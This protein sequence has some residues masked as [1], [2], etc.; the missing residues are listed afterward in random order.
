M[1]NTDELISAARQATGLDDFGGDSFREGLSILVT[2]INADVDRPAEFVQRNAGMITKILIDRLMVVD[3]IAQRPEV[4]QQEVTRPVFILGLPRTGTTLLSNLLSVDPARRSA[5]K[6]ELEN[7]AP[8]PTTATL[9]TDP[10]ALA[11]IEEDRQ[12]LEAYPEAGKHNPWRPLYPHECVMI[13]QHEFNTLA[14]ESW[15]KLPNYRDF[16]FNSDWTKGY[17]YHKKFL[18]LHQIDAPGIWN[19]KMPSHALNVETLLKVYPDARL[20]WTHRDPYTAAGSL[21]SLISLGHGAYA[22][23]V[24]KEWIGQNYPWQSAQ[25]AERIMDARTRIGHDRIIDF[26]YADAVRDPMGEMRKLYAALGDEFTPETEAAMSAWLAE[27][28][29]GKFGRHEYKL[30]EYGVTKEAIAP[31]F[32]RYISEY[33]IE[34]EG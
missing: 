25:H 2:D 8:P 26:H 14:L 6:W 22:G 33:K 15:G 1:L 28:P 12:M 29:Q 5:L 3:A 10:R 20:I 31:M 7:P 4:L 11:A 30:A 24:D 17:E 23:R 27:N 18:Q 21:C 34:M 16:V 32:E 9:F 13:F 19:L